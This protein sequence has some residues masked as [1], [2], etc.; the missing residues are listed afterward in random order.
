MGDNTRSV[1]QSGAVKGS[2]EGG[3]APGRLKLMI[4]DS[5]KEYLHNDLRE[6]RE[7]MLWRRSPPSPS[8]RPA[9]STGG[10]APTQN[11]STSAQHATSHRGATFWE[12]QCAKIERAARAAVT[13]PDHAG[14]HITFT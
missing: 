6:I 8:T 4:D 14:P 13:E 7:A 5:A 1:R 3:T 10:H 2:P 12:A 9:T 11:C